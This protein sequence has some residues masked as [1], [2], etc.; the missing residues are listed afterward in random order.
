MIRCFRSPII[1]RYV[2]NLY[3]RSWFIAFLLKQDSLYWQNTPTSIKFMKMLSSIGLSL[4]GFL[5]LCSSEESWAGECLPQSVNQ[6]SSQQVIRCMITAI[7]GMTNVREFHFEWTDIPLMGDTKLLLDSMGIA[8][9]RNLRK[10]ILHAHISNFKELDGITSCIGAVDDLELHFD[11]APRTFDSDDSQDEHQELIEAV[12]PFIEKVGPLLR[13]LLIYSSSSVDLSDL[14]ASLPSMP[15]LQRFGVHISF[16]KLHLS[17]PSRLMDFLKKH[18]S[19]LRHIQLTP[20]LPYS[21]RGMLQQRKRE[22][23]DPIN[24]ILVADTALLCNLESLNIPFVSLAKTYPLLQR[25]ANTL[26]SL[27]LTN[28]TLSSDE[29]DGLLSFF[30]HRTTDLH[31]LR[32]HLESF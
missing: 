24:D 1:S 30:A 14:F 11:Y 12:L 31:E 15:Q 28:H 9:G 29:V 19:T 3:I 10:L 13:N 32:L 17:D 22:I 6:L 2:R 5:R 7:K 18:S 25:S 8:F 16:E 21:K 4:K 23:W 20:N 26:T 27:T